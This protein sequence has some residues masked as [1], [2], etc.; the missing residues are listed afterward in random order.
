MAPPEPG[1]AGN[2]FQSLLGDLMNML[3]TNAGNQWEMTRSFALN[4][5]TGGTPESNVD[6][7]QRK[8]IGALSRRC[9]AGNNLQQRKHR[10]SATSHQSPGYSPP[11]RHR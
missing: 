6:P 3:G 2:P 11:D 9:R 5:A 10:R 8:L 1:D 4:V 7:V